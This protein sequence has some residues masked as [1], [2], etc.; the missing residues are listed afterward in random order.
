MTT[1]KRSFDFV[2]PSFTRLDVA[3]RHERLDTIAAKAYLEPGSKVTA[4]IQVRYE[5]KQWSRD[6]LPIG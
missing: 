6:H 5:N 1:T 4:I 3:V 2:A